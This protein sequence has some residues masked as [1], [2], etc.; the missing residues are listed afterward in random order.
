MKAATEL[1]AEAAHEMCGLCVPCEE[2]LQA[3]CIVRP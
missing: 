3:Q 1:T 2:N